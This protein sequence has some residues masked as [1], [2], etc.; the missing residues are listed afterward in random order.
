MNPMIQIGQ[1]KYKFKII[2]TREYQ[3]L[4]IAI[5]VAGKKKY[6][7]PNFKE[8]QMNSEINYAISK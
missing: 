4:F 2:V 6:Q 3:Y 5:F 8:N 7:L 1:V